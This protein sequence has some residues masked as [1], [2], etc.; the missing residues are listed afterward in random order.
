MWSALFL[1]ELC[2]NP[3]QFEELCCSFGFDRGL[4][5][6]LSSYLASRCG[7]LRNFCQVNGS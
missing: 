4:A 2:A 6:E 3:D 5:L 1:K 7:N